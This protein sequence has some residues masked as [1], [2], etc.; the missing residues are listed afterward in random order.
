M[1][2]GALVRQIDQALV[3]P[4]ASAVFTIRSRLAQLAEESELQL[5][6]N[7]LA[8]EGRSLSSAVSFADIT[9]LP[10]AIGTKR[11]SLV[12]RFNSA[13][14]AKAREKKKYTLQ[15]GSCDSESNPIGAL[16]CDDLDAQW[17]VLENA[18]AY[19]LMRF[20]RPGLRDELSAASVT[21]QRALLDKCAVRS[22]LSKPD[23]QAKSVLCVTSR[24][25][26][27][28][29]RLTAEIKRSAPAAVIEELARP[30]ARHLQLQGELLDLGYLPPG[31]EVDGIYG[32]QT[33]AGIQ[34]LEVESGW[35]ATGVM[36]DQVAAKVDASIT[37]SAPPD[38]QGVA[39][40]ETAVDGLR[41]LKSEIDDTK[42]AVEAAARQKA[43]RKARSATAL[44]LLGGYLE[45]DLRT[46][47]LAYVD[48]VAQD[49]PDTD[50][51]ARLDA[52]Y[53]SLGTQLQRA[54]QLNALMTREGRVL[55]D[56]DGGYIIL[57]NAGPKAPSVS[58]GLSGNLVFLGRCCGMFCISGYAG[59]VLAGQLRQS[60]ANIGTKRRLPLP[61]C[62][63]QSLEGYDLILF[64][65]GVQDS[66][67]SSSVARQDGGRYFAN[68]C[69]RVQQLYRIR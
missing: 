30:I 58:K 13:L 49:P 6:W 11:I 9:G 50:E 10:A 47:L 1:H 37:S 5:S 65:K 38:R 19:Y 31:A 4:D 15:S 24:Y 40:L 53:S 33:R 57:Y 42:R 2:F 52:R 3:A 27:E 44:K 28:T 41:K 67:R 25:T 18:R 12:Q 7:V 35:S 46:F 55:V 51:I 17:I 22:A 21:F 66:K 54:E 61:D 62:N 69:H 43:E 29:Q 14:S 20:L 34:L 39:E 63:L 45:D 64:S 59:R 68:G 56:N 32:P 26:A 23:K 16:I 36:T 60:F 8:T 48:A